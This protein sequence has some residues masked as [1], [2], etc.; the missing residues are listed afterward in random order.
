MRHMA[1]I[2]MPSD[3]LTDKTD[4]DEYGIMVKKE[5]GADKG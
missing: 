2:T 5:K 4:D 1:T 3:Y